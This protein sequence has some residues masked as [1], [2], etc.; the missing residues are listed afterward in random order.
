MATLTLKKK[1]AILTVQN[2]ASTLD[3]GHTKPH[4]LS[5]F[6]GHR[7]EIQQRGS[8]TQYAG[9]MESTDHGMVVLTDAVVRGNKHIAVP[10]D[11]VLLIATQ[12]IGHIHKTGTLMPR[13]DSEP[14][15]THRNSAAGGSAK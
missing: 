12:A 8:A 6:A 11:G 9:L 14:K 3:R 7:V 15:C 1:P 4:P 5:R 2:A 10:G 13:G